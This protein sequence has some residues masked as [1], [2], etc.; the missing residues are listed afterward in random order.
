MSFRV[1]LVSAFAIPANG[2]SEVLWH[3]PAVEIQVAES[4]LS[5]RVTLVG[6][7]PDQ[8]RFVAEPPLG[9]LFFVHLPK[10]YGRGRK[11]DA[12]Y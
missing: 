9:R 12:R 8:S 7:Y 6:A 3:S 5:F 11:G 2:F 10:D 1:A 4:V